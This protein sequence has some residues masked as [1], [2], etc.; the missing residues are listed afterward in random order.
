ME[1]AATAALPRPNRLRCSA[2]NWSDGRGPASHWAAP[3][4]SMFHAR[5]SPPL[6]SFASTPPRPGGETIPPRSGRRWDSRTC[7]PDELVIADRKRGHRHSPVSGVHHHSRSP[8]ELSL[9]STSVTFLFLEKNPI[10]SSPRCPDASLPVRSR[11]LA[12]ATHAS[13]IQS[14]KACTIPRTGPRIPAIAY[15]VLKRIYVTGIGHTRSPGRSVSGPSS[16]PSKAR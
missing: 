8:R 1:L 12:L 10:V 11:S 7:F 6:V 3:S 13:A 5:H 14:R 4:Q 16:S 2:V 15:M 9:S